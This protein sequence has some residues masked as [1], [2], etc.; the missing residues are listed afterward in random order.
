[1]QLTLADV[2]KNPQ[3]LTRDLTLPTGE[4]ITFRP[5]EKGD[6]GAL[7]CFL[8][9][10][11]PETRAF[12]ILDS[13]DHSM[14]NEMC[15]AINQY[16]KLRFIAVDTSTSAF[17]ALFEFSFDIPYNDFERFSQYG[18]H[19]ESGRDCRIGPC[20]S[21][22]FQDKKAGSALFPLVF[23]VARR[24]GQRHMILWGGVFTDNPR[25][26]AFYEKHGF[27]R[28]GISAHDDDKQSLDMMVTIV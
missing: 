23:D 17:V 2:E 27:E 16:D 3:E 28:L 4:T 12:Y 8:E 9:G 22:A 6:E 25:A 24:F 26:I 5:L 10:L 7:A 14:A 21:D 13:Y 20:I 18:F 1:M 19:L 15:R 11:S